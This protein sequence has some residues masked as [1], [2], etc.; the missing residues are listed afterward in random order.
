M[1]NI[2][3]KLKA[4]FEVARPGNHI[5]GVL[6][7]IAAAFLAGAELSQWAR[8]LLAALSASLV[9]AGGY[10]IN[11]FFDV[12]IDKVNR[13]DRP[14]PRGSLSKEEVWWMWR[15]CSGAGVVAAAFVGPYALAVVICWVILLYFY[16]K[17]FKR[18][19]LLGNLMIGFATGLAFI[20]GGV[21]A[22]NIGLSLIPAAFAFL[23]NLARELVKDIEDAEGD[24][25]D[26][27]VT[28]P[29]KH[30]TR[31][32]LVLASLT[33]LILIGTTL[34]AY[35]WGGY[36]LSYLA[37]VSL[38][39]LSFIWVIVSMWRNAAPKNMHVLSN[40]LKVDML[41]GLIAIYIGSA[42]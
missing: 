19:V 13:P 6:T 14:L 10:A 5:I 1:Q 32:A 37:I 24:A 35:R 15:L 2:G 21:V 18:S 23:V 11:D 8:I 4:Y 33:L 16:S 42:T 12:E 29:V 31:P 26:K 34:A 41:V 36:N 22:G 27:A 28:L 25:R 3:S 38:V 9:A 17:R 39:D 7:I 40:V 20:Y 30:G